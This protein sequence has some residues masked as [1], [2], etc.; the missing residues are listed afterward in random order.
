MLEA[1]L[2]LLVHKGVLKEE[3]QKQEQYLNSLWTR[4]VSGLGPGLD[5]PVSHPFWAIKLV[6][7]PENSQQFSTYGSLADLGE[8]KQLSSVPYTSNTPNSALT[9]LISND[10]GFTRMNLYCTCKIAPTFTF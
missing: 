6:P 2:D 1:M 8:C 7:L 5:Q 9:F 4:G 10:G 3:I